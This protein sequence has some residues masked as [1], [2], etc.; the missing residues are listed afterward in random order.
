M[1]V[2]NGFHRTRERVQSKFDRMVPQYFLNQKGQLEESP[3]MKDTQELINSVEY[4][5]IEEIYD[6]LLEIES[7][8]HQVFNGGDMVQEREAIE[9]DLSRLI[10]FDS[11]REKYA[12]ENPDIVGMDHKQVVKYVTDK[13]DNANRK[14]K[15]FNSERSN[16]N[17]QKAEQTSKQEE[18]SKDGK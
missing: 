14:I 8:M 15:E 10:E 13:L 17:A 18:L 9:D 2:N 5:H 4:T 3:I 6:R 1:A 7:A 11:I 16:N 12:S